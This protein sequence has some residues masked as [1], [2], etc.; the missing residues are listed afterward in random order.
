M[1]APRELT[2]AFRDGV[3]ERESAAYFDD[4]ITPV[5]WLAQFDKAQ[6]PCEGRFERFHF[7]GRQRVEHALGSWLLGAVRYEWKSFGEFLTPGEQQAICHLAAWDCRNGG[8]ACELHHRK[9]DSHLVSLPSEEIVVPRSAL[10]EHVEE[11]AA[12]WGLED[13]LEAKFEEGAAA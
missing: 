5:C 7:I 1:K 8:I 13:E 9:F 12:D 10:P 6:R 11:F 2:E 4:G 3:D